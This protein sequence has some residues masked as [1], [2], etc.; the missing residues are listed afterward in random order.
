MLLFAPLALLSHLV[1]YPHSRICYNRPHIL[2]A[3]TSSYPELIFVVPLSQRE[4]ERAE[5]SYVVPLPKAVY[6]SVGIKALH[7]R[8]PLNTMV[9]SRHVSA[10]TWGRSYTP[11]APTAPRHVHLRHV[12][13]HSHRSAPTHPPLP[14]LLDTYCSVCRCTYHSSLLFV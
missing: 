5:L 9:A 7:Q 12:H 1:S 14:R 8:A 11:S 13:V 6:T 10:P 4:R 2:L 3:H